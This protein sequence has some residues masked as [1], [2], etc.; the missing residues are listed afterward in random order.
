MSN[1]ANPVL[2]KNFPLTY[3]EDVVKKIFENIIKGESFSFI[4]MEDNC[5]SNVA[6]FLC[7]R[8]DVKRKYLGKKSRN[9]LFLY[10]DLNELMDLSAAGFFQLLDLSLIESLKREG[11]SFNFLS[12]VFENNPNKI[13]KSL[14][15]NFGKT[16]QKTGSKIVIIFNDFDVLNNLNL[17][18]IARNL[19]AL[20][21]TA[22]FSLTYIF[23]GLRP[24]TPK[25]SFF[26]KII[27][28]TPFTG[29]DVEGVVDRNLKRY[30]VS[31]NNEQKEKVI[32]LSGGHAGTIK[33]IVQSLSGKNSKEIER[34]M[35]HLNRNSD[36]HFQCERILAPLTELEK[37]KLKACERD[38][39]LV[40]IGVQSIENGNVN[41]FSP[42]LKD[43]LN[44]SKN[45]IEPFCLDKENN[46]IYYFGRP[47][48]KN[49][50][51]KEAD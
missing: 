33:F 23:I 50:T 12:N 45:S 24:F 28:M 19:T 29:K 42:L 13:L 8:S 7:F 22:R 43:Y 6:R 9:Y 47:L 21:N 2:E 27:W 44:Q 41:I 25:F 16:A 48:M 49:L 38:Y 34:E 14:K 4:G 20:R 18:L 36:I 26:R 31:L 30:N 51:R 46:E 35:I 10:V 32:K 5:K 37:A 17:D 40:N 3:R 11:Y 1:S 39:F 15:E